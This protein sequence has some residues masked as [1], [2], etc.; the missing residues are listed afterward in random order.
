M[1]IVI[2]VG[3]PEDADWLHQVDKHVSR[4]WID[5]CI[6]QS[7]YF[8]AEISSEA[9]GYLRH[10]WFWGTIPF[11]DVIWVH[12]DHRRSGVGGAMLAAWEQAAAKRGAQVLVTSSMSNE[13]EPQEWHRRNGFVASGAVTFGQAQSTPE[14]FFVKSL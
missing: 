5:R 13:P 14:V 12:P 11:L 6:G 1:T 4:D 10:S 3:A 7:E 2:R 8:V 9:I